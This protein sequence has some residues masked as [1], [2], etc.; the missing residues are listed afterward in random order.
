[1]CPG[2]GY[3]S[4]AYMEGS[5]GTERREE[6]AKRKEEGMEGLAAREN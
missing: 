3:C 4:G 2:H 6:G 5:S 1:M